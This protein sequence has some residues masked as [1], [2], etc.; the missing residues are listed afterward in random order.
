[1]IPKELNNPELNKI[2]KKFQEFIKKTKE[3]KPKKEKE[4][5]LKQL[6]KKWERNL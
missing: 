6:Y 4:L 2:R 3:A 1:M 5:T